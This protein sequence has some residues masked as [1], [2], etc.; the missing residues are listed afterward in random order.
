MDAP[1]DTT[2]INRLRQ[3]FTGVESVWLFGYGSLIY[4]ADFPYLERRRATIHGW[5]RRLWQGSHDHR[6]TFEH[7]GRVATL[8]PEE[9]AACVGMAYHVAPATFEHLD[10]REKNGYLRHEGVLDFGNG[11]SVA[12]L[13]YIAAQGNAAWLGPADDAT[14]ARHVA[15]ASGPSG[16]NSDYVLHL[17]RALRE[18]GADDPH[19]FAVEARLR[20]LHGTG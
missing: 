13:V 4:K 17:A 2:R 3:D 16:R 8:I 11:K 12:G 5:S 6:G 20:D 10:H 19:V 18:L 1:H 9:G 15:A 14:L 7:P